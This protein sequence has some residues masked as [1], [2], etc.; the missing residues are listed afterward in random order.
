LPK[1][2]ADVEN[3]DEQGGG[4][5]GEDLDSVHSQLFEGHLE[6][7]TVDAKTG[8]TEVRFVCDNHAKVIADPDRYS[9]AVDE[10]GICG[11]HACAING[12]LETLRALV[13][14]GGA[15]PFAQA[16]GRVDALMMARRRGHHHV[17]EYLESFE[18]ERGAARLAEIAAQVEA[19]RLREAGE[20]AALLGEEEGSIDEAP[21]LDTE[22]IQ[23]QKA[24]KAAEARAAAVEASMRAIQ[25]SAA[26]KVELLPRKIWRAEWCQIDDS[27]G[28]GFYPRKPLA[29]ED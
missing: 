16:R 21:T 9:L 20:R 3:G 15:S 22:E 4:K 26:K 12:Y 7:R 27:R 1:D 2:D 5:K 6:I 19:R 25:A 18:G 28:V 13:E 29:E 10:D 17:L 23:A 8:R 24:E 11:V 14:L